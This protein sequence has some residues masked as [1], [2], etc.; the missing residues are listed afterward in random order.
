[1]CASTKKDLY[2]RKSTAQLIYNQLDYAVSRG[3]SLSSE[4]QGASADLQKRFGAVGD[5]GA[6]GLMQAAKVFAGDLTYKADD[7][8]EVS[9]ELKNLYTSSR[10]LTDFMDPATVTKAERIMEGVDASVPKANDRFDELAELEAWAVGEPYPRK[11]VIDHVPP[12]RAKFAE[13]SGKV[14]LEQLAKGYYCAGPWVYFRKL[15]L[16]QCA[17]KILSEP[18]I[19]QGG[20]FDHSSRWGGCFCQRRGTCTRRVKSWPYDIYKIKPKEPKAEMQYYPVMYFVDKAFVKMP[21]TCSGDLAA[22]P[23]VTLDSD[24]CASA[25]DANIHDCVGYQFFKVGSKTL[26]FLFKNFKTG[27]YYTGCGKSFLQEAKP[28]FE[29]SCYA[30]FSKFGTST[31]KP[32][33]SGKCEQCFD[34][35]TKADRCYK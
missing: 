27:V 25:C 33:P 6:T 29:A 9:T 10:S 20:H 31:L 18:N 22:K 26:C 5:S 16:Q 28:P 3:K 32:N 35:L 13:D 8:G 24:G 14:E 1:M 23:I 11:M 2:K 34:Q 30:K 19:C 12:V 17:Q 4:M 21:T 15:N 7:V